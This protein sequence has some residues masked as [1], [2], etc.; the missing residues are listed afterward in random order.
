MFIPEKLPSDAGPAA[1]TLAPTLVT[2][3]TEEEGGV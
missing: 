1:G 2:T 3:G